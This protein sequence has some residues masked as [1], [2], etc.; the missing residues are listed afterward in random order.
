MDFRTG[1]RAWRH[2]IQV[3]GPNSALNEQSVKNSDPTSLAATPLD[4]ADSRGRR[5]TSDGPTDFNANC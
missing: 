5:G 2:Y 4:E 1:S 3:G